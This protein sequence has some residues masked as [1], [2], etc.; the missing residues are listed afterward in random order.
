MKITFSGTV[1]LLIS[2][3]PCGD[4]NKN[5]CRIKHRPPSLCIPP[6]TPYLFLSSPL[7]QSCVSVVSVSPE[8]SV[9]PGVTASFG[10]Q[11]PEVMP[12]LN[13]PSSPYTL[14]NQNLT[15][16]LSLTLLL[17]HSLNLN[18]TLNLLLT[19]KQPRP[20]CPVSAPTPGAGLGCLVQ[21]GQAGTG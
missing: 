14:L 7:G 1:C 15:Q 20:Q 2:L 12:L 11:D 19:L 6:P 8:V 18:L 13:Q 3:V 5:N 10:F 17:P 16:L 4:G 9:V 21:R